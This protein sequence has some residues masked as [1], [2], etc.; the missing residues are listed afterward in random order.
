MFRHKYLKYKTKYLSSLQGG[1]GTDESYKLKDDEPT[2]TADWICNAS[3]DLSINPSDECDYKCENLNSEN[4]S[5]L[6]VYD[7]FDMLCLRSFCDNINDESSEI[8]EE[9]Y[10]LAKKIRMNIRF[11][12]FSMTIMLLVEQLYDGSK[13]EKLSSYLKDN[14]IDTDGDYDDNTMFVI[15]SC[16]SDDLVNYL[17]NDRNL[18]RVHNIGFVGFKKPIH[19]TTDLKIFMCNEHPN[20]RECDETFETVPEIFIEKCKGQYRCYNHLIKNN[21]SDVTELLKIHIIDSRDA[22]RNTKN[23]IKLTGRLITES[24]SIVNL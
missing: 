4:I 5:E 2:V 6:N 15:L 16:H 7:R 24:K 21:C 8:H 9:W 17:N 1:N 11:I 13:Y 20:E 19:I 18:S 3:I 23:R 22:L 12:G 14:F 10:Q